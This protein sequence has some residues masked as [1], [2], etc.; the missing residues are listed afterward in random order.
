MRY[1]PLRKAV[2]LTGLHP[3][4][5]RKYA[6]NGTIP[7][8]RAPNGQ[9]L[10]DLD[11]WLGKPAVSICYARVSSYKQRDD[12]QRQVEFLKT[13]YPAAEIVTDIGSGLNFKRKGL[14]SI[15]E[16]AMQGEQ[17][18]VVV[19]HSDR[20]ARFAVELIQFI[21]ERSG[22]KVVVH[23]KSAACSPAEE[24]TKDL[25]AVL[26]VFGARMHGLRKYRDEIKEDQTLS[27]N[28]ATTDPAAMDVSEP[29]GVQ[30]DD[31]DD[32][33]DDWS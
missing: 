30:Q 33:P 18:T 4:T 6:D 28:T 32:Q 9:R 27:D 11:S 15:L 25:L 2:E 1:Q 21:I 3:N 10:F 22:G 19:A 23:G 24:L 7:S 29:L 20:L 12:L 16:R 14:R 13:R 31:R 17:L 5:L 8:K 26:T